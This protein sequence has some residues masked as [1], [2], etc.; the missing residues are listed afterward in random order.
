MACKPCQPW[1]DSQR[2][3]VAATVM[4]AG[5]NARPD[6]L[7]DNSLSVSA[8]DIEHWANQIVIG[9]FSCWFD[10]TREASDQLIIG[11]TGGVESTAK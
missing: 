2:S 11:F 9:P 1:L 6:L 5:Q 10:S 3:V 8:H 7:S 4:P